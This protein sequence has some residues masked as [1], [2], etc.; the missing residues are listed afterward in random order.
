M[1]GECRGRR[2]PVRCGLAGN[3]VRG[4]R[5]AR[6]ALARTPNMLRKCLLSLLASWL[7]ACGQPA[8]ESCP[9]DQQAGCPAS[10][11]SYDTGIGDLLRARCV[12]CHAAGGVESTRLLTDYQHVSGL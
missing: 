7:G 1:F 8:P 10:A 3:A 12:P 9:A 4:I 2:R 11:L 6:R 5:V